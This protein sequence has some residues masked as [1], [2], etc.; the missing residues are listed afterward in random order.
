MTRDNDAPSTPLYPS[1]TPRQ[2]IAQYVVLLPFGFVLKYTHCPRSCKL[3][4]NDKRR[5][6]PSVDRN[7]GDNVKNH[8][9][10]VHITYL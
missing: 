3:T 1:E 6:V 10:A 7:D 4:N 5:I 9:Y 8:I 2:R